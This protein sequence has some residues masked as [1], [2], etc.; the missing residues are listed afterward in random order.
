[1]IK[2]LEKLAAIDT[3]VY[4]ATAL[5]ELSKDLND[6]LASDQHESRRFALQVLAWLPSS[7]LANIQL[8]YLPKVIEQALCEQP[9]VREPI[10]PVLEQLI[11]KIKQPER[12]QPLLRV[13]EK[14]VK[15]TKPESIRQLGVQFFQQLLPLCLEWVEPIPWLIA[16]RP[17]LSADSP[18][19]RLLAYKAIVQL[20]P[21]LANEVQRSERT[22]QPKACRQWVETVLC[23]LVLQQTW[24]E[25][26]AMPAT[27]RS[28]TLLLHSIELVVSQRFKQFA[29]RRVTPSRQMTASLPSRLVVGSYAIEIDWYAMLQ[30][31]QPH[32]LS[33][34][35]GALVAGVLSQSTVVELMNKLRQRL[36]N[37]PQ[38]DQL[39]WQAI[40]VL[41][42]AIEQHDLL[43]CLYQLA[44]D[45]LEAA[46]VNERAAWLQLLHQVV[47]PLRGRVILAELAVT[48]HA[49]AD[50]SVAD[51]QVL[52]LLIPHVADEQQRQVFNDAFIRTAITDPVG[53][54]LLELWSAL[55]PQTVAVAAGFAA[56]ATAVP[57]IPVLVAH[58]ERA[59]LQAVL[60]VTGYDQSQ[61]V[62]PLA[63]CATD[64]ATD[65]ALPV[66]RLVTMAPESAVADA[67]AVKDRAY[68]VN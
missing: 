39:I 14:L 1:L 23:K 53:Q 10:L 56:N 4:G 63:Y 35:Q 34:L 54:G 2:Q 27:K 49:K 22:A 6:K 48:L 17:Q 46:P 58:A 64:S 40:M 61:Q 29:Q 44:A 12:L 62:L 13:A 60:Q 8:V 55:V 5:R 36:K 66:A 25:K 3:F 7:L 9:K 32:A 38:L 16:M 42:A 28:L 37:A 21:L 26:A 47:M 19:H 52:A 15:K 20:V 24:V 31:R 43:V 51:Y 67:V 45:K 33:R 59:W 41:V 50:K 65:G 30:A 11:P 68:T 57:A 18:T